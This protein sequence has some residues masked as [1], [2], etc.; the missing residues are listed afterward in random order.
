M[1]YVA[2]SAALVGVLTWAAPLEAQFCFRGRPAREC[3]QFLITE[4]GYARGARDGWL[5]MSELGFMHNLNDKNALGGTVLAGMVSDDVQ[6]GLKLRY[7]RWLS[8]KLTLDASPGVILHHGNHRAPGFT[9]HVGVGYG[10]YLGLTLLVQAIPLEG[11]DTEV[12]S[13]FGF[14]VGSYLGRAASILMAIAYPVGVALAVGA[15]GQD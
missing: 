13:Y 11:E 12:R 5:L 14:R 6:I 4:A 15:W 8:S 9:G 3:R 7:R 2:I 1:K 10:D